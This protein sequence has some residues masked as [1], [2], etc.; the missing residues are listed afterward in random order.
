MSRSAPPLPD[1]AAPAIGSHTTRPLRV[2]RRVRECDD[3]VALDL[4]DPHGDP[5]PAW[6]P[7][8]HVDVV[9]GAAT[10]RQYSLCGDPADH[11]RWRLGILREAAGRGGSVMLH[12]EVDV[13]SVLEVGT[14][15]NNFP[16]VPASEH[17][18]LGGGI[19]ITPLLPM[20]R[21]LRRRGAPHRLLHATRSARRAPFAREVAALGGTTHHDDVEGTLDVA[22]LLGGAGPETAV[23]CCGPEGLLAAV[24][25][26][27]PAHCSLHVERF[28]P[29]EIETDRTADGPFEVLLRSTGTVVQ[30]AEG[31]SV[32]DAVSRAGVDVP[33]SCREGTCASCETG[34]VEGS[35]DHRDSMLTEAERAAGE[36][37]M[38][39]VSRAR[40]PRLV[41][42]L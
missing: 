16:L 15:R 17:L 42:D 18:L 4:V 25:A 7:G 3:T 24:E 19:G 29:R 1:P 32:L 28:A 40:G 39:C 12:D 41:L 21:E 2:V 27:C 6:E 38:I 8:A 26:G 33:S 10:V 37:M 23:Y 11:G 9:L 5:L 20:A 36:T 31:Q 30:V 13:D 34:V 14:P 35:V 22:A